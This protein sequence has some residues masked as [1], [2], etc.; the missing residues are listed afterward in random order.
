MSTL[1]DIGPFHPDI[2]MPGSLTGVYNSK[3]SFGRTESTK[4]RA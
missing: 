1:C 2:Y 3:S 4:H